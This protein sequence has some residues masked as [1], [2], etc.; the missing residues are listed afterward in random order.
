ML[1]FSCI[2]LSQM[3]VHSQALEIN[4][5]Q[6]S[7]VAQISLKKFENWSIAILL[8]KNTFKQTDSFYM[9][10]MHDLHDER[11]FINP[12]AAVWSINIHE[13]LTRTPTY[14]DIFH[15]EFSLLVTSLMN[16]EQ[17]AFGSN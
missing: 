5:S 16:N 13:Q 17:E 7:C 14:S 3:M 4:K 15:Q 8:Y 10:I 9:E 11:R 12:I 2:H 1:L 6:S